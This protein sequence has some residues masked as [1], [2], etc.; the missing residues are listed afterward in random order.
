MSYHYILDWHQEKGTFDRDDLDCFD[1]YVIDSCLLMMCPVGVPY[2][3]HKQA[4]EYYF[5]DHE[6]TLIFKGNQFY[7]PQDGLEAAIALLD[8]LTLQPGDT[9]A[10]FFED[11]THDQLNW[12]NSF[13]CEYLSCLI[14][15]LEDALLE[16]FFS[17]PDLEDLDINDQIEKVLA[18]ID[19]LKVG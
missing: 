3:T 7:S 10:E 13:Q 15:D 16:G 4:Y 19:A 8:F 2:G 11:Y 18:E 1:C 12:A 6:G 5:Y 9:D 17:D 14:R